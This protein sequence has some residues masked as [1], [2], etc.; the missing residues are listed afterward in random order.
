[1]SRAITRRGAIAGAVAM[2][3]LAGVRLSGAAPAPLLR[4]IPSS[5][6]SLPVI[7]MGTSRTFDVGETAAEREPLAGVLAA[8]LEGG[9]RLID[10]SP[11]YGRAEQVTGDLLSAAGAGGKV[12]AATKVWTE[13]REAGSAQMQESMRRMQVAR[14]DLMQ[15]H[16][17]KDWRTH[18]ATLRAWKE[19]GR[20]RYIGI[21]T[22]FA[23][24]YAEFE[25]VMR[26]ESLDFVQL[27][28]SLG[29]RES[30]LV[31]LPLARDRG[32]AVLVNRPFMRADLFRRVAGRPLPG[33]AA[34]IGCTSWAQVFLK[35]IIAH[36]AVTCAI[37]A[38]ARAANMADNMRA[39][40]GALPDAGLRARI[41]AEVIG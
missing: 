28:Y 36:P 11:M 7:G 10:S 27:N 23:P 15:V 20:V 12:F 37:P 33:W 32:M 34:D 1:M 13:G 30:E 38:S 40:F 21:T 26:A 24:Q 31:L 19:A 17:L 5:G 6:E 14:F 18:L 8:F 35:W 4:A 9:G 3:G 41:A 39:G 22:S 29:E 25:A 2:A 16:N